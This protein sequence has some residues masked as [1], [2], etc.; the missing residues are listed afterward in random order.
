MFMAGPDKVAY[1]CDGKAKCT[2]EPGCFARYDPVTWSDMVCRHTLDGS[3]AVNGI[4]VDPENHP[5]RFTAF[6]EFEQI[7]FYERLPEEEL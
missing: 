6:P 5:E 2:L 7:K 3:H 1:I 4:C